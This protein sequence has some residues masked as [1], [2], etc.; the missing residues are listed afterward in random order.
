MTKKERGNQ[1]S[2]LI[3]MQPPNWLTKE[4]YLDYQNRR[5][6]Y[7]QTFSM[8]LALQELFPSIPEDKFEYDAAWKSY[9]VHAS[10]KVLV[11]KYLK[12]EFISD[13]SSGQDPKITTAENLKAA[14]YH[15][16]NHWGWKTILASDGEVVTSSPS[17]WIQYGTFNI[18]KYNNRLIIEP[19][20]VEHRCWGLIGFPL[21]LVQL[22]SDSD[23]WFYHKD[24][25]QSIDK[26]SGKVVN[27]IK[28]ND[29]YLSEIVEEC[30]T[31]GA[32]I[33]TESV[34]NRFYQNPFKFQLLPFYN[35]TETEYF[36]KAINSSSAKSPAQLFHAE[37]EEVMRW[38]KDFSSPKITKF[39]PANKSLH[40]LYELMTD[41][42]LTK[43]EAMMN[44]HT[45]IQF[46]K[47]NRRFVSHSDSAVISE[48]KNT[49]GYSQYWNDDVKDIILSDLD[50]LYYLISSSEYQT[51]VSKQIV[52]Q[53]L[54]LKDIIDE[55][56]YVIFDNKLFM[57]SFNEWFASNQTDKKGQMT[58]FAGHWRKSSIDEYNKAY[59]IIKNDF[60]KSFNPK[61][62]D[63]IGICK[64]SLS[65]P[66]L[67]SR[68]VI[69]DSYIENKKL[70]IDG[71]EL[72]TQPVGGHIISDMEL[73]R[74]STYE[75]NQAFKDENISNE[76]KHDS[77]CRAMSSY[78][79]L[80]MGVLRLSEYIEVIDLDDSQLNEIKQK[81]YNELKKKSILV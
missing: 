13:P 81:K 46:N 4:I 79:N 14:S 70:D 20:N 21:N 26:E 24:L 9:Q 6:E 49:H 2:K 29:K 53:L 15:A 68:D 19:C 71:S 59:L 52:Q 30:N 73:I 74:M 40:P 48:Y 72:I 32:Y 31:L 36:F 22:K 55:E 47:N 10:P 27:R 43:L 34:L 62:L 61:T 77:N 3:E 63:K 41:G 50:F 42:E 78:H 1:L 65:I 54:R 51:K 11:D 64:K 39:T 5:E 16:G 56:G 7:K 25:P 76:Y 28:V 45:I 23:L 66:R 80:R 18:V 12:E 33:T 37:S 75:R 38:V 60:L 35:Q 44:A 58:L 17:M 8:R 67:F 57:D 69:Y